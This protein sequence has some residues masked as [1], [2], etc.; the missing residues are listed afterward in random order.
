MRRARFSVIV[1]VAAALAGCG[2]HL[3]GS[4][5]GVTLP[6]SLAKVRIVMT[7]AAANDPLAVAVRNAFAQAGASVVDAVDVPTV[8]L[9]RE[10]VE[11]RVIGV[12]TTTAKANQY[13]LR[14]VVGFQ[15]SGPQPLPPQNVQLQRDFNYDPALTLAKEQ[16]ERELVRDM[17]NEAAQII[18]R[19]LARALTPAP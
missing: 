18:V 4:S 7:T 2:F 8:S 19:R 15:L 6:A 12:S 3:R 14:Y 17:R 10:D 1:L 9:S 13:R 11:S 16:E 5:G